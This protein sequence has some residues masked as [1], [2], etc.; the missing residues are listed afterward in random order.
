MP[1]SLPPRDIIDQLLGELEAPIM[2]LMWERGSAS[3]REILESLDTQGRSLAYTSVLTVMGRLTGKD[4]LTRERHG[5][6]HVYRPTTTCEQFL[7]QSA[8]KRVYALV[9]DFGDVAVAQ[10][11]AELTDLSPERRR[12]LQE[13]ASESD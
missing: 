9:V 13:L 5:K 7:R 3:V 2:R 6:K 1:R 12:Q 10:F 8:A 4:L 11:L